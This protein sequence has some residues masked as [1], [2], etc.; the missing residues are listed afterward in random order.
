MLPPDAL[1]ARFA[2]VGADGGLPVVT[3]CGTGVTAAILTLGLS[4]AG[5]PEGALYDG[6]WT[7]WAARPDT[8]KETG[9]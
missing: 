3:S 5:L 9:A 8:P 1:R 4:V 6:S 7:E 2:K